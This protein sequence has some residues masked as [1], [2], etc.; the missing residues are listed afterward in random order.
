LGAHFRKASSL[1]TFSI[2]QNNE[3]T[4]RPAFNQS[5]RNSITMKTSDYLI[6]KWQVIKLFSNEVLKK[7]RFS[8][9]LYY[10]LKSYIQEKKR[11]AN[12]KPQSPLKDNR[13]K[14]KVRYTPILSSYLLSKGDFNSWLMI[15][16]ISGKY[17]LTDK[18]FW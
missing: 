12:I 8:T 9:H 14:F 2:L 10:T 13:Q 5:V 11:W 16:Y 7:V 1:E 15:T 6:S 4:F 17:D 3:F 18:L